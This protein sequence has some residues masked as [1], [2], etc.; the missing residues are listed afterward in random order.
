[1][2]ADEGISGIMTEGTQLRV[3]LFGGFRIEHEG[4]APEVRS[5][6]AVQALLAY[7]IL[8]HHC[9]HGREELQALFWPDYHP[10]Q[11]QRCLS[12][13]LWRARAVLEPPHV[14]RG[15]YLRA[16][17]LGRIGFAYGASVAA[18]AVEFRRAVEE[19]LRIPAARLEPQAAAR[20]RHAVDQ[21][22]AGLL[23]GFD[24]EWAMGERERLNL[25]LLRGLEHLVGYHQGR[26]EPAEAFNLAVRILERDPLRE[27][28]HRAVML[29][30][31]RMGQRGLA[32]QHY[33][34]CRELLQRELGVEP[35]GETQA[36]F[37][38]LS[39]GCDDEAK[40]STR[41]K[42]RAPAA[43]RAELRGT[44]ATLEVLR[45]HL[46]VALDLIGE[47][48][49]GEARSSVRANVASALAQ[50]ASE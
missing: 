2:L 6:R 28:V 3:F 12:T 49:A 18:D 32:V 34:A 15:T 37:V 9:A 45:R 39:R 10:H 8:N 23:V 38:E 50:L 20:L 4:Q 19:Q 42:L 41:S 27:S 36:L 7:L 33:R 47:A 48:D 31:C 26:A 13:A 43:L 17:A 16:D 29:C 25:L 5:T 22:T 35:S 46:E 24:D 30:H 40:P 44:L 14:P 21:Y 11:A 1:M